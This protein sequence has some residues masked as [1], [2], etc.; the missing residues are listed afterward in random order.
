MRDPEVTIIIII[1]IIVWIINIMNIINFIMVMTIS[2]RSKPSSLLRP[3]PRLEILKRITIMIR[4]F[5]GPEV[6]V[7][8]WIMTRSMIGGSKW[9]QILPTYI[10]SFVKDKSVR[11]EVFRDLF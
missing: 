11:A 5:R 8:S 7:W 6:I 4:S 9:R 1:I 2:T 3:R 10:Y